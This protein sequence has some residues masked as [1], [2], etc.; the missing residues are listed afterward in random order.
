MAT[1]PALGAFQTVLSV[2]SIASTLSNASS[3]PGGGLASSTIDLSNQTTGSPKVHRTVGV[4]FKND[5]TLAGSNVTTLFTEFSPDGGTTYYVDH[6][7]DQTL[8]ASADDFQ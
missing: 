7:Y 3:P 1:N 4:T 8:D 6:E 2:A 5:F